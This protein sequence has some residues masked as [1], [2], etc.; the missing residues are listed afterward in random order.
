MTAFRP[1]LF[2]RPDRPSDPWI[3]NS[4]LG[5]AIIGFS[6]VFSDIF[7]IGEA[8]PDSQSLFSRN[9]DLWPPGSEFRTYVFAVNSHVG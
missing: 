8:Q 1:Q 4:E 9:L 6:R 5:S 7:D 2:H 3:V